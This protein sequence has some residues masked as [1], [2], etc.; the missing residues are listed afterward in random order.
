MWLPSFIS[1]WFRSSEPITDGW[2]AVCA[3]FTKEWEGCSLTAYW[4]V[5]GGVWTIGYGATGPHITEGTKWTQAQADTDLMAR[6]SLIGD[7]IDTA[8]GTAFPM[9]DNEKA[10]LADFAYNEGIAAFDASSVLKYLK[11]GMPK[12]A[13]VW[14]LKYDKADGRDIEGLEK[15]RQ[16]EVTL[17]QT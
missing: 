17:F 13:M 6:L 1:D 8:L 15:R 9:T 3:P 10:A 12:M 11:Q 4:D 14:L 2:L 16:A 5:L 7:E